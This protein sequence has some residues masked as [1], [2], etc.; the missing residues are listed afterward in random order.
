MR[1]RTAAPKQESGRS[2]E[3]V[4]LGAGDFSNALVMWA[5]VARELA[6]EVE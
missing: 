4:R 6:V 3:P 5:R 2:F 1:S